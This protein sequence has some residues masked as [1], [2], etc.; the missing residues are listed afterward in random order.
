MYEF[1]FCKYHDLIR[2][3][4]TLF[5]HSASLKVV[6]YALKLAPELYLTEK[7]NFSE[8]NKVRGVIFHAPKLKNIKYR[9]SYE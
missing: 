9:T 7:L 5:T 4:Q 8:K 2:N 1:E 6:F 3:F